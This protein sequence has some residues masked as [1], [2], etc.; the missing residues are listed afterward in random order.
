M[1]SS[2]PRVGIIAWMTLT[3]ITKYA[4]ATSSRVPDWSGLLNL[5]GSKFDAKP[6]STKRMAAY[7]DDDDDDDDD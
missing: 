7:V 3:K 6:K 2:K 5:R 4:L 1:F